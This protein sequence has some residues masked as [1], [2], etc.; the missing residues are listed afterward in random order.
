MFFTKLF[1]INEGTAV[2]KLPSDHDIVK[3]VKKRKF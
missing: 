3:N 1:E 2:L